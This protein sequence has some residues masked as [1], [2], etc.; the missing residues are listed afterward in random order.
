MK[1]YLLLLSFLAPLCAYAAEENLR[2]VVEDDNRKIFV[3]IS[4]IQRVG[5]YVRAWSIFD[6]STSAQVP[7]RSFTF[8]SD[9]SL[10]FYDCRKKRL[11]RATQVLYSQPGGKGES[12]TTYSGKMQDIQFSN[13]TSGTVG[14]NLF[15]FVC[16]YDMKS[17]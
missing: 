14:E 10:F 3:D 11:G 4:S 17:R 7:N 5:Q 13:V 16:T 12:L 2:F 6:Y 1:K 15:D 8:I 9:K